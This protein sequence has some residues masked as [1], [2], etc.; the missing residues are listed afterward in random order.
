[1][2]VFLNHCTNTVCRFLRG[3]Q[4]KARQ[5]LSAPTLAMQI[6]AKD[7]VDQLELGQLEMADK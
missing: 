7:Y 4:H 2:L 3:L 1:M 6:A 5:T